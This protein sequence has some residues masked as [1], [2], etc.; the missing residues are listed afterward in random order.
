MI[1]TGGHGT[2]W[3]MSKQD[4]KELFDSGYAHALKYVQSQNYNNDNNYDVNNYVD[5]D[6]YNNVDK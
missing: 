4:K 2:N 6:T 1:T 5:N 3:E